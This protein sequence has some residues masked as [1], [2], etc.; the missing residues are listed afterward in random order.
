MTAEIETEK[1][2]RDEELWNKDLIEAISAEIKTEFPNATV[3]KGKV[4]KDIFLYKDDRFGYQLQFGFVDQDIVIYDETMDISDFKGVKNI[5]LHNN[6]NNRD[7]LVIPKII[8]EL[9]YN[10]ITSHGLI[11]YSSY[12]A[13]I[14]SIFPECKYF[15]ALRHKKSSSENKLFR[16]GKYFDKIIFLGD[17]SSKQ[18]YVQGQFLQ[19]LSTEVNLKREILGIY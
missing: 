3:F 10:G 14:K 13:D 8:C 12:A 19:E 9:K 11:T 4:L 2:D 18:K 1:K 5:F 16:H 15:L 6:K 17:S 7:K